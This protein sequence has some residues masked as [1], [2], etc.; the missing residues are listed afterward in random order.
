M[1][2]KPNVLIFADFPNWAYY[3]IQQFIKKNLNDDYE[4]FCD[5][6]IFNSLRKSK[7][8]IK[9]IKLLYKRIK[10]QNIS[11]NNNYDIVLY[12]GFYFDELMKIKWKS[13]KVIK[14]IY[15][16]SFPPKNANFTG[17]LDG[18]INR[19]LTNCDAIVCGSKQ[20]K[21][22]YKD[23][24]QNTYY[25]NTILDENLFKRKTEKLINNNSIFTIGWTGNPNREFKGLQSHIIPAIKIAK[26]KYPNIVFKTRYSGSI[27]TL[28]NFYTDIDVIVIASD[29][30]AGPS[31]FGE[32][33]LM[34]VPAISTDIGWPHEVIKNN[35]N[36]ITVKK[37]IVDIANNIIYL[38]E[39][40]DLLHRMSKQ[41]RIDYLKVFDK[42]KMVNHWKK[43]F[44][45][46]L[47]SN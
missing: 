36:G 40:R 33:S 32:A 9:R 25:A 7:N 24:F 47:K 11:N 14:G 46:V 5:Y 2:K 21:N 3:E 1:K 31:L 16:D 43:M 12:L 29:A 17:N 6:L 22:N 39:N 20:I 10:Y 15:T 8:P 27:K 37:N 19:F 34:E 42:N 26:E 13:K 30:D 38:Y 4:I 45:E 23:I 44:S 41:I 18:F 35:I 28:P